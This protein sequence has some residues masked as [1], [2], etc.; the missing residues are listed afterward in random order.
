MPVYEGDFLK[1]L[2]SDRNFAEKSEVVDIIIDKRARPGPGPL[3][4]DLAV[5]YSKN[6]RLL[7][8][9]TVLSAANAAQSLALRYF[10]LALF[11]CSTMIGTSGGVLSVNRRGWYRHTA[12]HPE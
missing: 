1:A 5:R 11:D 8:F 10:L 4:A 12:T 6:R 9:V 2:F 7:T 3:S